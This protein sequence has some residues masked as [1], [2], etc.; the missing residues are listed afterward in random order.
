MRPVSLGISSI[1]KS[2]F[3]SPEI[4]AMKGYLGSYDPKVGFTGGG[5]APKG[6][7]PG[8]GMVHREGKS[9]RPTIEDEREHM[10]GAGRDVS[11]AEDRVKLKQSSGVNKSEEKVVG[12][13]GDGKEDS[14]FDPKQLAAGMK[15]EREHTKDPKIAKEIAKDHLT[16]DKDYYKKLKKIEKS[17]D[18]LDWMSKATKI[19]QGY[20]NP[21]V[22]QYNVAL[23]ASYGAPAPQADPNKPQ[24]S[25]QGVWNDPI[26][27]SVLKRPSEESLRASNLDEARQAVGQAAVKQSSRQA[28]AQLSPPRPDVPEIEPETSVPV[29]P[30][31]LKGKT[32]KEDRKERA[33][34]QD[35]PALPKM[36]SAG[37][38]PFSYSAGPSSTQGGGFNYGVSGTSSPAPAHTSSIPSNVDPSKMTFSNTDT[39]AP[40]QA[41]PSSAAPVSSTPPMPKPG[42]PAGAPP[43]SAP[44]KMWNSSGASA[45]GSN[46]VPRMTGST[47]GPG[48]FHPGP[49]QEEGQSQATGQSGKGKAKGRSSGASAG[50]GGSSAM[51]GFLEGSMAARDIGQAVGGGT[52][53]VQVGSGIAVQAVDAASRGALAKQGM[54]SFGNMYAKSFSRET[55]LRKSGPAL[56]LRIGI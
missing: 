33:S 2:S 28:L 9:P 46:L 14:D 24:I 51:R 30:P 41:A 26:S 36:S 12:G 52:A 17:L 45:T 44:P 48:S 1:R 3:V 15:V 34:N 55:T 47:G 18:M 56:Y 8:T 35:A 5:T 54:R 32:S 23:P 4:D 13:L 38:S 25:A 21:G 19:L 16:E 53:P 37:A 39:G 31:D 10:F 11:A 50:G 40:K 49:T 20:K 27:S 29:M 43:S 22:G 7:Q 42:S 6:Y